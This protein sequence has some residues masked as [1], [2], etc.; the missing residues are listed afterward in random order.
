MNRFA[1]HQQYPRRSRSGMTLMELLLVLAILVLTAAISIPALRG[2][3]RNQQLTRAGDIVRIEWARAHIQAM[4][5]G[6]ILMFRYQVGGQG[7][8]VEPWAAGD[9]M[10]ESS[11]PTDPSGLN[12][13]GASGGM[14]FGPT[15]PS[16]T[17]PPNVQIDE[18]GNPISDRFRLPNE[19]TFAAGDARTESRAMK[20]E[21]EIVETERSMEWSRPIMFYPDGSTSDAFV[22]VGAPDQRGV[23]IDLR[24]LT[25]TAK[26]SEISTVQELIAKNPSP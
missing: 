16:Q 25:G 19:I 4:K 21:Q 6:R 15:T 7:F 23:R 12:P 24:G 9:D 18:N 20:I 11:M 8:R 22:I 2:T 13:L 17:M 26:V 10:L 3:L 1:P 14:G 5:T